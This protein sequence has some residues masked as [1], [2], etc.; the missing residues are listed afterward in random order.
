MTWREHLARQRLVHRMSASERL[1]APEFPMRARLFWKQCWRMNERGMTESEQCVFRRSI[2]TYSS[3]RYIIHNIILK[4]KIESIMEATY[5]LKPLQNRSFSTA[6]A[7]RLPVPRSRRPFSGSV[8]FAHQHATYIVMMIIRPPCL[9]DYVETMHAYRHPTCAPRDFPKSWIMSVGSKYYSANRRI[10]GLVN[11]EV[12][13]LV[14]LDPLVRYT[15]ANVLGD[16]FLII[17]PMSSR[18]FDIY[19]LVLEWR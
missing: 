2:S 14:R 17:V 12:L 1:I 18:L 10:V 19:I 5:I 15:F 7:P 11:R 13:H 8:F 4:I 6:T 3:S 9:V 16:A